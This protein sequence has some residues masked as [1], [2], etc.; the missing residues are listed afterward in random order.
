MAFGGANGV[1]AHQFHAN[2]CRNIFATSV[3]APSPSSAQSSALAILSNLLMRHRTH[4][5][6]EWTKCDCAK[7]SQATSERIAWRIV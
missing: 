4:A 6:S 3:Y 5:Q 1:Y 7:M 2:W